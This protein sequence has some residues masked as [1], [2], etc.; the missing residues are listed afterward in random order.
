MKYIDWL[1]GFGDSVP[2]LQHQ[3]AECR[4]SIQALAAADQTR[5]VALDGQ[6]PALEGQVAALAQDLSAGL[7][8]VEDQAVR[9]VDLEGEIQQLEGHVS[10]LAASSIGGEDSPRRKGAEEAAEGIGSRLQDLEKTLRL[11]KEE[12]AELSGHE[13]L[14]FE[15]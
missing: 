9:L 7:G 8:R 12:V 5:P 2:Q 6:V 11:Q 14:G 15:L 1:Q 4:E 10:A 13:G 3:I